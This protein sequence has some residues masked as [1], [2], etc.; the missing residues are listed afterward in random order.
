MV[1]PEKV[2]PPNRTIAR[3]RFTW[4]AYILLAVYGY[5]LNILGPITPYLHNEFKL[6]YA[7]SSLHFSAFAAGIL[8]VGFGGHLVVQRLGR[9]RSLWVG[10]AGVSLNAVLLLL[11][12]TGALTLPDFNAV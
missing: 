1:N 10:A 2:T 7:V 6:S 11:G 5:L 4:L 9:W 8:L 3:S 12:T